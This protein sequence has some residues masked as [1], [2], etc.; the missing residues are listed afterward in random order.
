VADKKKIPPAPVAK[1]NKSPEPARPPKLEVPKGPEA[2]A[3]VPTE[4]AATVELPAAPAVFVPA[5]PNIPAAH[6]VPHPPQAGDD[7]PAS[8]ACDHL[9]EREDLG[10]DGDKLWF[11]LIH[12]PGEEVVGS[13]PYGEF[14][15]QPG[16]TLVPKMA[17]D[18]LV[19]PGDSNAGTLSKRGVCRIY[20]PG[21]PKAYLNEALIEQAFK[22]TPKAHIAVAPVEPEAG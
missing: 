2:G 14:N 22:R 4:V 17:A 3:V 13:T 7:D 1:V 19:G 18:I 9:D 21:H 20:R 5:V 12:N 6:R 11:S 16:Q 8:R 10:M 15:L